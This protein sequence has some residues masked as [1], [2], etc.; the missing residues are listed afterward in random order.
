MLLS[1][2]KFPPGLVS[3]TCAQNSSQIICMWEHQ[4]LSWNHLSISTLCLWSIKQNQGLPTGL[5]L[6]PTPGGVNPCSLADRD[7]HFF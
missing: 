2:S 4:G 7:D 6:T 1:Y 5:T 3:L